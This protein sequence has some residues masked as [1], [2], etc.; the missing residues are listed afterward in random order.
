[1]H[2]G[3]TLNRL[4][5]SLNRLFER[6]SLKKIEKV[7]LS[8]SRE[9]W[10]QTRYAILPILSLLAMLVMIPVLLTRLFGQISSLSAMLVTIPV[11][12]TRLLGQIS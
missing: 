7:W 5:C 6:F 1:M 4:I 11:L 9:I 3:P 8:S 10:S 12:L 2:G